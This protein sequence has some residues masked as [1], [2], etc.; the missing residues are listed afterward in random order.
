MIRP[1]F[2][3]RCISLPV[4]LNVSI[5]ISAILLVPQLLTTRGRIEITSKSDIRLSNASLQRP[6]C[7]C[8]QSDIT[9]WHMQHVLKQSTHKHTATTD[10]PQAKQN[11]Q[12]VWWALVTIQL[13]A[14]FV[15][16]LM[17]ANGDRRRFTSLAVANAS[18]K[19]FQACITKIQGDSPSRCLQAT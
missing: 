18:H 11:T 5:C 4:L 16:K 6:G 17:Y 12:Y 19:I 15:V 9:F 10:V 8:S 14:V 13:S 2:L 1:I 3:S 7:L